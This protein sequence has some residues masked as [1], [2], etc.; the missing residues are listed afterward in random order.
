M[1]KLTSSI[2]K[3]LIISFCFSLIGLFVSAPAYSRGGGGGGGCFAEGTFILTSEGSKQIEQLH[4]GDKPSCSANS[5]GG[6]PATFPRATAWLRYALLVITFLLIAYSQDKGTISKI[7]IIDS[8]D[9]YLIN[10]RT[11]VTGTRPFYI[12]ISE[13][14]KLIRVRDLHRGDRLIKQDNFYNNALNKN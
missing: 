7:E 5:T 13:G 9:Y 14:I 11:K 12:K 2:I 8:P 1:I 4:S 3:I 6:T 10:D